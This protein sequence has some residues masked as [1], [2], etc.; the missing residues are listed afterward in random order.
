MSESTIELA[1][2]LDGRADATVS[3]DVHG[4]VVHTRAVTHD[5]AFAVLDGATA[6]RDGAALVLHPRG[7]DAMRMQPADDAPRSAFDAFVARVLAGAY[8]LPE[9]MRD[10]RAYGSSRA[11]PGSEHDRYFAPLVDPL[12]RVRVEHAMPSRALAPWRVAELL[13]ATT[14][15][16]QWRLTMS[17]LA[18]ARCPS[19]PPDCRA[20]EAELHDEAEPLFEALDALTSAAQVLGV[21][22]DAERVT[23][24]RLWCKALGASLVAADRAW[25]RSL[26][27]LAESRR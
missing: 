15:G 2:R 8:A 27:A 20:L 22:P 5:I 24:W 6:D 14:V 18:A 10:L 1:V 16:A 11:N 26:P 23:A 7:G 12:R 21:A 13:D 9:M 17:A 25:V 4:V 19:S 3:V